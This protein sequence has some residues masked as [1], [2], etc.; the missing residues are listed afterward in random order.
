MRGRFSSKNTSN[1]LKYFSIWGEN[2]EQHHSE[3][4]LNG[5]KATCASRVKET[6]I[7]YQLV[8]HSEESHL[9][10]F[11]QEVGESDEGVGFLQVQDQHGGDERHALHLKEPQTAGLT[12]QH[13]SSSNIHTNVRRSRVTWLG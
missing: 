13:T 3:R 9:T 6:C 2:T 7:P 11:I 4:L 12:T 1:T 10:R 8:V 5:K